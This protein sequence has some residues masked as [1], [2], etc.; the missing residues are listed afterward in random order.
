MLSI[1]VEV[2]QGRLR[3]ERREGVRTFRGIPYAAPPVGERRFAAPASP[4][5]WSGVRDAATTAAPSLQASFREGASAVDDRAIFGSEDCLYLDVCAPAEPGR[6]PVLVWIH[7]G[8]GVMGASTDLEGA[9]FARAGIVVVTIGYRLGALGLLHLP[10]VFDEQVA[11]NFSLLDQIAAL[12]WVCEN[13]AAFDGDPQ[14]VTVAGASNGGRTVGSLL[15]APAARDLFQQAVVMSGT[16]VGYLVAQPEEAGRVTAAVL[17]ELGL[18]R[19]SAARLRELSAAE[20]VAAQT[21]IWMRWPTMLPFQV[22]VDGTSMPARPIDAVAGG[23]ASGVRLLIGTTHDERDGYEM[24]D[25][26]LTG[27]AN[28]S[29]AL[30]DDERLADALAAYRRLLPADWSEDDVRRH[31]L[32]SAEW[33][34]PAIRFAE[35]H[36]GAGGGAWMYRIDWR[37]KPR[38]E[39]FGAPHGL[40]L[41]LASDDLAHPWYFART[42]AAE[43][44]RDPA[45]LR[46]VV[47]EARTALA[48][49]VAGGGD[50]VGP[51]PAYEPASRATMLLDDPS[52]LVEDPDR[53]LRLAWRGIL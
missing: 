3:G 40:D 27:F 45:S 42:L 22:V 41:P 20:I 52:A 5:A 30:V 43:P 39:G 15:A 46:R 12:R 2:A 35:A 9:P 38:G 23:C 8:A 37:L 33:W 11:G 31:T 6:Y 29:S 13:V 4:C 32:T 25:T 7:G 53:E 17:D 1:E 48:R 36:I 14:R 21:R 34:I 50:G 16:G 24:V 18:D 47:A 26:N 19:A 51:W 28:F 44:P 49:F 10:G